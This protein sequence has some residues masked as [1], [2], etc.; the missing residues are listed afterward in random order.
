MNLR[1]NPRRTVATL[2]AAAA[3]VTGVVLTGG[4]ASSTPGVDHPAETPT[5]HTGQ[6]YPVESSYTM[7][8]TREDVQRIM[9][10]HND[11]TA[12]PGENSLS[13]QVSMPDIPSDFPA[14]KDENGDPVWVWDT[15]PMTDEHGNQY[16]YKGWDV[17]FS[18]TADSKA[19]YT[20]D[21]RHVN[22]RIGYWFRKKNR[23]DDQWIYGG[24]VFGDR[25]PAHKAEWSGSTRIYPDGTIKLFYTDL[26]FAD[27]NKPKAVIAMS[28]GRIN[29][30]QDGVSF[31]G[32]DET[33]PLLEPDGVR[34]QN[35][36]Q[37]AYFNFR[38]PFTFE[39]P[40]QP[41]KT[42]MVF[43][44]NTAGQKGDYQ[45]QQSDL[46]DSGETP[47]DVTARGANHQMAN[48][49]LAVAENDDLTEWRY[50][51]PILSANCV[52]DQTERPQFVIEKVNGEWQYYLYTISHAFTYAAGLRGPDG[53]YG[54]VGDGIRSDFKPLNGSGLA[55][56]NP[57]NL[58][59][60]PTDDRKN[61]RQ[62]QSYSHYVMPDGLVESF[63]DNVDGR[64]GG[65]L[66]PTVRID[67]EGTTSVV[68]RNVGDDGLLPYGFIPT[69]RSAGGPE[70][71]TP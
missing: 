51:D 29:A 1:I 64:R 50:L 33:T 19:G 63:I 53:V 16:S 25:T 21:D 68:D 23:A 62:Y 34:Y 57:S 55:L 5:D 46:G 7:K 40:A 39:D 52:N 43:E 24:N 27:R 18:L 11:P 12:G 54:F 70:V 37:N 30:D 10:Q 42:F 38:D 35:V 9:S 8:W 66:A 69:N 47:E 22:A 65:T 48:I 58:N 14:M 13:D 36:E 61:T 26:D 28:E 15:W 2:T 59:Y 67:V 17:I 60:S 31:H 6:A 41:G 71:T 4:A 20:F 3:V 56:G 32:L 45:C 44:G 49:G